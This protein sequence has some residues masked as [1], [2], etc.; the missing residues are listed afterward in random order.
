VASAIAKAQADLNEALAELQ[1]MPAFD[2]GAVAFAAHALNNYLTVT[3][4]T[5][6]LALMRL[7]DHP[8]AQL[9][10]WLEG[11]L[12]AANLMARLAAQL[13]NTA[14]PTETPFRLE[15][16]DLVTMVQRA[17]SYYQRVADQ[18]A[19]RITAAPAAGVPAVW[20]DRVAVAAV[21]DNLLSNAIKF[22]PPGSAVRVEVRGEGDQVVCAVRDS[23]PG[24]SPED[25][26]R[27]F[28]RGVRLTPKPTAGEPS[29]GY[30]LAV[31]KEL[32]ESLGG[33]IWCESAV[34]QGACFT[35]RLPAQREPAKDTAP[36]P[37]NPPAGP[38]ESSQAPP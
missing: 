4:G 20:A 18:K 23:G 11:A 12:H 33:R 30:G 36:T 24:L 26:A 27:L 19:I 37:D 10:G 35:F 2:A 15:A 8:D 21:L 34:G 32:V 38:G 25:Q 9:R 5:I 13:M 1:K 14:T 28:Q 17:C 6:E 31:A 3:S 7:A 22:S 16:F 29:T